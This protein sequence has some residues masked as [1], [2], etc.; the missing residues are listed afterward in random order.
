[1]K[2]AVSLLALLLFLPP[3]GQAQ[4]ATHT[5]VRY[6]KCSPQGPG[7]EWLQ[8]ARPIALEMVDEGKFVS[9]GILAHSWGDEWN[10]VDYFT[11][12]GLDTFFEH[13]SEFGQRVGQMRLAANEDDPNAHIVTA[14]RESC[15][16]HKD[17][18]YAVVPPPSGE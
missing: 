10:V 3:Q 13:F 5:V 15:T 16:E 11:V 17:V 7:I 1:M 2:H 4:E 6:W 8:S 9:Y 12:D 18:I 14:F